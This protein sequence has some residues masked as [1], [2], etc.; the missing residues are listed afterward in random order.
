LNRIEGKL[1][2]SRAFGDFNYKPISRGEESTKYSSDIIISE[3][4][5]RVHTLDLIKD[6]FMVIGCDGLFDIY[7]N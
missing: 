2:V 6:E 4:E 7:N 1:A 5:I 3:P